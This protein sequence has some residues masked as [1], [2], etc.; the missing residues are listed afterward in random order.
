MCD[1]RGDE[2]LGGEVRMML[3]IELKGRQEVSPEVGE[4]EV[5]RLGARSGEVAPR[6]HMDVYI[7]RCV[8]CAIMTTVSTVRPL[9]THIIVVAGA[10][11]TLTRRCKHTRI[12]SLFRPSRSVFCA[13]S[14]P[15]HVWVGSRPNAPTHFLP[16]GHIFAHFA[17]ISITLPKVHIIQPN[18]NTGHH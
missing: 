14:A 16:R 1:A 9:H 4:A 8:A 10:R 2:D 13:L 17:Y 5:V 3:K 15:I 18:T 12:L 11:A 7:P 6:S